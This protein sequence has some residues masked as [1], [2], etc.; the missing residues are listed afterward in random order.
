MTDEAGIHYVAGL[1]FSDR[2]KKSLYGP[3]LIVIA[4][5]EFEQGAIRADKQAQDNEKP[6]RQIHLNKLFAISRTE[7]TVAQFQEFIDN[8]AY[9]TQAERN[10]SSNVF[11]LASG[12]LVSR[13]GVNWR[14]DYLGELAAEDYPVVHVSFEDAKA[15]VQWLSAHTSKTYRLPTESEWEFTFRAGSVTAFPW[16]KKFEQVRQGNLSGSLDKMPNNRKWGNAIQNYADGNWGLA[17]VRQY[18]AEGLGTFDMLGN[19]SEWVEDCWHDNYRR[20]PVNGEAWVNPG[21][22]Q[23]VIR[24]SSWLSAPDQS[25]NSFRTSSKSTTSN[26]I[27][28]FRVIRML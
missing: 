3:E 8:S 12:K 25:R 28:G 19:A 7:I 23:R 26:A 27:I 1:I 6:V 14:F 5:T 20:A 13:E 15:Y 21:C 18:A 22:T 10:G 4:G 24:G 17:P 11:D 9:K 2:I 16:G